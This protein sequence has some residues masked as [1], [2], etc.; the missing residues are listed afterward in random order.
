[1]VSAEREFEFLKFLDSL[2]GQLKPMHDPQKALR[3][4]LRETRDF[5]R[6]RSACIAVVQPGV[7]GASVVCAMPS[8][9]NWDFEL[10]TRVV[11][12]NHPLVRR[13]ILIVPLQRRS[14]PWAAMALEHNAL[15]DRRDERM[16]VRVAAA[17]SDAIQQIDRE[18]VL[19]VRDRIDRK[20]M[21]QIHPKDVFYQILQGLRSLTHYDHSSALLIRDEGEAM[22]RLVAEQIAWAKAKSERIGLRLAMSHEV[23]LMLESGRVY[24]FDRCGDRWCEWSKEPV[25]QLA[26]LLDYNRFDAAGDDGYLEGSMLVA[27]LSTREGVLGVLKVAARHPGRL[28]P[29]DAKL[30]EQ[31]RSQAAAAVRNLTRTESFRVRMLSA[32]RKHAMAE[33]A[34]SVSHDI[35]NALGSM[36]PLVQQM[37]DDIDSGRLEPPVL[38]EDLAQVQRSLQVCRR[39]FGGMLAFARGNAQRTAYGQ[40]RP[41]IDTAL[42]I[43]KDG[44]ERRGIDLGIDIPDSLAPVACAQG[45]LEQ[46][47]LNLLTNAREAMSEGGRLTVRV[48]LHEESVTISIADTGCGIS[49]ADLPR[50]QEPFFT[51]KPNGNGLGLSICRSILWQVGGTLSILSEVD[52]GTRVEITL[53]CV[54]SALHV[55]A[56]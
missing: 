40:I 27:P 26:E 20:L 1:M 44:I 14:G 4:A 6:A 11:R 28:K 45:E 24:G 35:N 56:T 18:R 15:E 17:I 36:L 47:F 48:A 41:A 10:F 46:V 34:R 49:A 52:R 19:E 29:Y 32:E 30:V 8:T 3:H 31:F 54:P 43:L 16:L 42:A 2:T 13:D 51:T 50:V 39:I 23:R 21:E 38:A 9:S 5:F 33:L 22:L 37:R 7:T 25:T 53:P 55:S 12:H